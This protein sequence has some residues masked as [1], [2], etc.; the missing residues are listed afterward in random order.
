MVFKCQEDSFLKQFESKVKSC[1]KAKVKTFVDGNEKTV[2]GYEVILEDTILFPEG[3]GQP[4]DYGKL[5]NIPV[6]QVI[7]RGAEAVHFITEP[8]QIGDTVKQEID[9]V[10]RNDHMQQ[11]SGQHLISAIIDRDFQFNTSSWW[12]GEDVSYIELDTPSMTPEQIK[13][14]EDVCNE[15]IRASLTVSVSVIKDYEK[16]SGEKGGDLI[17]NGAR[18]RGLPD[19]HVGDI[20][21]ITIHGIDSHMCCGTHVTNL[22]QLQVIKLLN[23]EKGKRKDKT[24]VYFLV[25]N[26]VTNHFQQCLEREQKLTALLKNSPVLHAELVEKLQKNLKITSKNLQTILKEVAQ[27]EIEKLK[28]SK[29]KYFCLHRKEAEPDFMSIFVKELNGFDIFL[30]LS[31]GDEKTNGNVLIYG[32]ENDVAELGPK[33]CEILNGKGAGKNGRYQAKVQNMKNRPKCVE[34]IE[35]YFKT[36]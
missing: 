11:H 19:D 36:L 6:F 5:N 4:C 32:K 17:I 15:L 23:A 7:R 9:W 29:P 10:R 16:K 34:L 20:R 13:H 30:F 3:G 35:N 27:I 28:T 25:G 33:I 22:S 21:V 1:E 24:L 8:F 26:R 14:A 12:L 2:D 18:T 31:V